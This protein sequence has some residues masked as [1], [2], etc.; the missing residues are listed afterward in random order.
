MST[1]ALLDKIK[2]AATQSA[3]AINTEAAKS[4]EAINASVEAEVAMIQ[5]Q[6]TAAAEKAGAA[7]TRATLAKARQ[8]GKL[9]VQTAR[10]EAFDT[11][12]NAAEKVAVGDDAAKAQKWADKRADLEMHLSKE[13]G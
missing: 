6:A 5:E 1:Q 12:M 13:I 11:I 2:D 7:V 8:T 10:R 3:E 4:V 9:L